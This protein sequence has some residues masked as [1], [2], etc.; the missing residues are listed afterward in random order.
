MSMPTGQISALLLDLSVAFDTVNHR[1][2]IEVFSCRFRV[3]DHVCEW[4]H[5]CLSGLTQISSTPAVNRFLA[6]PA[7]HRFVAQLTRLI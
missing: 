1:I 5:S 7:E 2:L 4:F 6:L 3:D